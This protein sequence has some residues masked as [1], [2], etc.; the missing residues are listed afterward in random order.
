MQCTLALVSDSYYRPY[1]KDD[2][3]AYV[4]TCLMFQQDKIEQGAPTKFLEPLPIPER[5]WESLSMDFIVC[6]S[7]SEGH[8]WILVVVE[9]LSSSH[10]RHVPLSKPP[11]YSSTMW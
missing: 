4:K 9:P 5:P 3:E 2:V 1:L 6:L 11:I 7:T 10:Q 8:N